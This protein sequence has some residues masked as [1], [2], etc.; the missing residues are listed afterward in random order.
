MG[1][2]S[3]DLRNELTHNFIAQHDLWQVHGCIK[4]LREAATA[5]SSRFDLRYRQ[6]RGLNAAWYRERSNVQRGGR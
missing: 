6:D 2:K 1:L 5:R 4:A 3:F